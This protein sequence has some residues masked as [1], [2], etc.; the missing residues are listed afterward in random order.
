MEL[1]QID[2]KIEILQKDRQHLLKW[3]VET[4]KLSSFDAEEALIFADMYKRKGN[5]LKAVENEITFLTNLKKE[6]ISIGNQID[7]TRSNIDTLYKKISEEEAN[8]KRLLVKDELTF[9]E[10]IEELKHKI[11]ANQERIEDLKNE[12]EVKKDFA[13]MYLKIYEIEE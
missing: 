12:L 7:D 4:K 2:M 6:I 5:Q 10:V 13:G 8:Y 3:L 9:Q 11:A 1:N